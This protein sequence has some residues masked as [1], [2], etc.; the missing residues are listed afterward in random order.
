MDFRVILNNNKKVDYRM[1][2]SESTFYESYQ[3]LNGLRK[4]E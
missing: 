3:F 1:K 2:Y 4:K